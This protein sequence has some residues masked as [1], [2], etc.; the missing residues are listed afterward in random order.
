VRVEL[1]DDTIDSIATFDPLT[2]Q[3]IRKVPRFTVYPG[4]H[5]VTPR[6]G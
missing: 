4:T 5:Y 3:V 2:G 1:F 6:S